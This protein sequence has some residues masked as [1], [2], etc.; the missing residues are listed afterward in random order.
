AFVLLIACANIAGLMIARGANQSREL[1]MRRALGA[2]RWHL[3]RQTFTE[4]LLIVLGG[5]LIGIAIAYGGIP[6]LI[7][8][9]PPNLINASIQPDA[10]VM[11][12][13]CCSWRG[14][15]HRFRNNSSIASRSG[16]ENRSNQRRWTP[17][18]GDAKPVTFSLRPGGVGDCF[19]ACASCRR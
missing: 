4:S 1:A 18:N 19:G 10:R 5:T 7:A 13:Y 6:L 2:G 8:I 12:L 15:R 16:P 9:A 14:R 11:G 3:I 17:W